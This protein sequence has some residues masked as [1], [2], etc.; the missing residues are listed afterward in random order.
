MSRA[1][2]RLRTA[3]RGLRLGVEALREHVLHD[4]DNVDDSRMRVTLTGCGFV[5]TPRTH[6][7]LPTRSCR[8]C[9]RRLWCSNSRENT[10]EILSIA[11]NNHLR[12]VRGGRC[13]WGDSG[14][15]M[16][17]ILSYWP[18][19]RS[20][21]VLPA[22]VGSLTKCSPPL[23]LCLTKCSP[24]LP[25]SLYLAVRKP[26]SFLT[27]KAFL[28]KQAPFDSPTAAVGLPHRVSRRSVVV[29][30]CHA[31]VREACSAAILCDGQAGI[32]EPSW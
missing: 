12:E 32:G 15:A 10:L 18:R 28:L 27:P 20:P 9:Y 4:A 26:K 22:I 24:P 29:A 19:T 8:I 5:S 17:R 25:P 13:P 11:I 7:C 31:A 23:P 6:S 30:A 16:I 1:D 3:Q 2:G 14:D 21:H